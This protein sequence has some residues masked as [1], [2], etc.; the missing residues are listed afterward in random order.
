MFGKSD[1]ADSLSRDIARARAKRDALASDVA[2]L[3][4]QIAESEARLSAEND[5]RERER[6]ANEIERIKK[7]VK[8]QYLAFAPVIAGIRDATEMAAAI[9]PEAGELDKFLLV[10]ATEV[11]NSI[12]SLLAEL[13]RRIE[14]LR[15]GNA[16]PPLPLFLNGSPELPQ[17]SDG[18]LRLPERLPR[19][20]STKK[21][22]VEDGCNTAAA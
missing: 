16:A 17:N 4:A 12:D 19:G 8:D 7:R 3:T 6:A 1:F 20:E 22:S 9:V 11:S 10:V 15:T 13:D 21:E 5:R 14:P 2:T 18:V